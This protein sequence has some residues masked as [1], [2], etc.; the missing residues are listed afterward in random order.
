MILLHRE[1]MKLARKRDGFEVDHVN[2]NGLDNRR[3]NLRTV[4]HAQNQQNK[5]ANAH[6]TSRYRGVYWH[7]G[8]RRWAAE[9]KH[10]GKT[11]HLGRYTDEHTAAEA[12]AAWRR[13]HFPYSVEDR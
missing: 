1:L 5:R 6:A 8:K 10:N 9:A 13:E 2:G 3:A 4:T 12:V 11:V 7:K